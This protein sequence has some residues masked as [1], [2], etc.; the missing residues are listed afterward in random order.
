[1]SCH[2][3]Y[4]VSDQHESLFY[5]GHWAHFI[6][7]MYSYIFSFLFTVIPVNLVNVISVQNSS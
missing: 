4:G 3:L 7:A 6:L 1:M 2:R 5:F